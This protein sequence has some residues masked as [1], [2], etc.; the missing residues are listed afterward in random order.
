MRSVSTC[1]ATTASRTQ[2]SPR[3]WC[4]TAR[5]PA[6][7]EGVEDGHRVILQEA[8][9]SRSEGGRHDDRIDPA[10][11]WVKQIDRA[12]SDLLRAL[13][14]TFVEALATDRGRLTWLSKLYL[15]FR[16]NS[17][18]SSASGG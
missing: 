10:L 6:C 5:R 18:S 7:R 14:K 9:H 1:Q 13:L 4:T 16:S 2:L 17:C 8:S 15:I 11:P 12:E 3:T